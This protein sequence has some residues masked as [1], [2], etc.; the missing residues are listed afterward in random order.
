MGYCRQSV[1]LLTIPAYL[2]THAAIISL[3]GN[4]LSTLLKFREISR[5]KSP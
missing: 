3:F 5:G 4:V 1:G 2:H